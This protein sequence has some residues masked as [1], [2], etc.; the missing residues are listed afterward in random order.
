MLP[1]S[2]SSV[3][4]SVHV[5]IQHHPSRADLLPALL[6]A[7]APLPTK[8]ST[9]ASDPPNPWEGY[10]QC[11]SK[12]PNCTH[13]LVLQDDVTVC[14]NLPLAVERIAAD[15]PVVLFL[16]RLPRRVST[17]ALREAKRG[18]HYIDTQ[19][20]INEF[21]PACAVLWP[22]AKAEEFMAWAEANPHKL[23]HPFPRSDDG[24]MGRWSALS[25]QR[26]R[27]LYP[28][29]VEHPDREVSVIGRKAHWGKDPGRVALHYIGED[30]P[31]EIDWS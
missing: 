16:A 10:K 26:I 4:S 25:H 9:H 24:V 8:V 18:R 27:F 28:S 31:L 15:I 29:L 22:K 3:A 21:M 23:G 17:L 1:S 11:L 14:R 12:L 13:L 7:L 6:E 20:R 30:D 5:R 19:L 2:T